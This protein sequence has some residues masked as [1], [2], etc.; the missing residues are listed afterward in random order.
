MTSSVDLWTIVTMM[1]PRSYGHLK[2]GTLKGQVGDAYI[3]SLS[4]FYPV[5]N[6]S[7][8]TG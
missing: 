1:I 3:P 7:V 2:D 6:K 4:I 8:S 5:K